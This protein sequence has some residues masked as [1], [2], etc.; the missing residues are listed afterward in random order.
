MQQ[1]AMQRQAQAQ[2]QAQQLQQ[3]QQ[4]PRR[5]GGQLLNGNANGI[6]NSDPHMRQNPGSANAM[7]A[8]MYEDKLKL[9]IQRE[10][11]DDMKVTVE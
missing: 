5:D 2:A 3:Q 6:T 4:Q 8:K 1:L 7:A 9:P 10:P 11:S